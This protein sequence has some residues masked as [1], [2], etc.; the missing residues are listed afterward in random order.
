MTRKHFEWAAREIAEDRLVGTFDARE[1]HAIVTFC[2]TMIGHFNGRFD[3]DRFRA[4]IDQLV[5]AGTER[6]QLRLVKRS[7]AARL[8]MVQP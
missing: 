3:R 7:M 1:S 6:K 4:R 5:S 2:M 8:T